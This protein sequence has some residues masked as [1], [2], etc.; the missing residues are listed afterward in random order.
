MLSFLIDYPKYELIAVMVVIPV[1]CNAIQYWITDSFIKS[2]KTPPKKPAKAL[3]DEKS[4]PPISNPNE[5]QDFSPYTAS[6]HEG[7]ENPSG[8]KKSDKSLLLDHED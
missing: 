1:I 7:I 8:V 4:S 5:C 2:K 3:S 6:P